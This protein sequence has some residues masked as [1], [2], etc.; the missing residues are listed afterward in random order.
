MFLQIIFC[1]FLSRKCFT[2]IVQN[3]MQFVGNICVGIFELSSHLFLF[4]PWGS[5]T[6]GSEKTYYKDITYWSTTVEGVKEGLTFCKTIQLTWQMKILG[7]CVYQIM[8]RR[9]QETWRRLCL[10]PGLE[11]FFMIYHSIQREGCQSPSPKVVCT[12]YRHSSYGPT[13]LCKYQVVSHD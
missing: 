6:F 3:L 4:V 13:L 1:Q 12:L 10:S 11:I 5:K 8:T 7:I 9:R 2:H